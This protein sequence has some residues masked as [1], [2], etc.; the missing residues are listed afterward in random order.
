MKHSTTSLEYRKENLDSKFSKIV[1]EIYR[2]E[3]KLSNIQLKLSNIAQELK[4]Y[5]KTEAIIEDGYVIEDEKMKDF[6]QAIGILEAQEAMLL[7]KI[8]TFK[9]TWYKIQRSMFCLDLKMR[10]QGVWNTIK[11]KILTILKS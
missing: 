3:I 1:E 9:N 8:K 6:I 4:V 11:S 2:C 10:F 5:L 7:Y